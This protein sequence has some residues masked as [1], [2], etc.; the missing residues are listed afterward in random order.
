MS[1]S[2]NNMFEESRNGSW[3]YGLHT[4]LY[5]ITERNDLLREKVHEKTG[6]VEKIACLMDKRW[7]NCT[8]SKVIQIQQNGSIF[9]VVGPTRRGSVNNR[10]FTIDVL[11]KRFDCGV[12]QD[13]GIPCLHATANY[14]VHKRLMLGQV[15]SDQVPPVYTYEY[16][17][18]ILKNNVIPVCLDT[19]AHDGITLPPIVSEKKCGSAKN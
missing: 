9:T 4:M 15:L 2:A 11:N 13:H 10:C 6:V 12:W 7:K 16:Q 14:K 17:R 5:E 18:S 19:I 8:G 1:E 3:L